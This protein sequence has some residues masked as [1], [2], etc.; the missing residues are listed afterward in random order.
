MV[1]GLGRC[2]F[3]DVPGHRGRR[4]SSRRNIIAT[5]FCATAKYRSAKTDRFLFKDEPHEGLRAGAT[6]S[7]RYGVLTGVLRRGEGWGEE[8]RTRAEEWRLTSSWTVVGGCTSEAGRSW[9]EERVAWRWR[10]QCS[11]ENGEVA[12]RWGKQREQWN[13]IPKLA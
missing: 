12:M 9:K 5:G 1:F 6:H 2:F 4:C 3:E 8:Q 7:T 10:R 11:E 13:L